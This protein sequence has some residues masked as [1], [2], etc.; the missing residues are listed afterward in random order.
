[1]LC[2]VPC[3]FQKSFISSRL[4]LLLKIEINFKLRTVPKPSLSPLSVL[5]YA[6]E[7]FMTGVFNGVKH[8]V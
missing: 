7:I 2:Y 5:E 1:M 8:H 6:N 3:I 4:C